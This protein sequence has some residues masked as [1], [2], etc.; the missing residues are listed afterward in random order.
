MLT[1]HTKHNDVWNNE[2]EQGVEKPVLPLKNGFFLNK[3]QSSGLQIPLLYA[4][5][6]QIISVRNLNLNYR[7]H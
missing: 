4:S 7:I 2:E 1:I 3:M 5:G 6:L